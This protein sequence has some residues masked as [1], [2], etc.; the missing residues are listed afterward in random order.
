MRAGAVGAFLDSLE[1]L[2]RY[3]VDVSLCIDS[4]I[5]EECHIMWIRTRSRWITV[6]RVRDNI[7]SS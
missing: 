1:C 5:M 3:V 4:L 2:A 7:E 6:S